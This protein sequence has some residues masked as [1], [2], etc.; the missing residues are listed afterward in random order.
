MRCCP[1]DDAA[2]EHGRRRHRAEPEAVD[3]FESDAAVGTGLAE[4]HAEARLGLR[5]KRFAAG[6]LA[7]FGAAQLE[8]VTP[9]RVFAKVVIEGDDAVD[10]GARDIQRLGDNR[11]GGPVDVTERRLQGMK[12][13][14]QRAFEALVLGDDPRG[15]LRA[16][17]FVIRHA[18]RL[19]AKPDKCLELLQKSIK[20]NHGAI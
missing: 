19:R 3:R 6:G 20:P 9:R 2:V 16:P 11:L 12:D 1:G 5:R 15:F 14:Q 7:G 18:S 17:W 10:F 4:C 13:R 8:H